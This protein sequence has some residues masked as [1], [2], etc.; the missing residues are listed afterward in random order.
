MEP[1]RPVS[2]SSQPLAPWEARE[3]SILFVDEFLPTPKFWALEQS[4]N[5]ASATLQVWVASLE[6][7]D[8]QKFYHEFSDGWKSCSKIP[9]FK[10][11]TQG[12]LDGSFSWASDPGFKLRSWLQGRRIKPCAGHGACLRFSLRLLLPL[13]LVHA[14]ISLSLKKN[15]TPTPRLCS[16]PSVSI[17]MLNYIFP[18]L[19]WI[20]SHWNVLFLLF[21]I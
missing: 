1:M 16:F 8:T 12:H 5:H 2:I 14:C 18:L 10:T 20:Y 17:K 21:Y 19:P 9:L 6:K 3:F 11:H 4:S 13:P 15:K 7:E